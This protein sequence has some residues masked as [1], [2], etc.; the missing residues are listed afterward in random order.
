MTDSALITDLFNF[1]AD[2]ASF[3][4]RTKGSLDGFSSNHGALLV[5]SPHLLSKYAAHLARP[6]FYPNLELTS[7]NRQQMAARLNCITLPAIEA[8]NDLHI[9]RARRFVSDLL[10]VDLSLVQVMLTRTVGE[11]ADSTATVF[12]CGVREH[13][14]VAPQASRDPEGMLVRQFGIAGY[15]AATRAKGGLGSLVVDLVTQEMA[16]HFA[17]TRYARECQS[18]ELVLSKQRL[19][20]VWEFAKGIANAPTQPLAF[21]ASDLGAD[22]IR[23]YGA[24]FCQASITNLYDCLPDGKGIIAGAAGFLGYA[25]AIA[26]E[27]DLEGVMRLIRQYSG[28]KALEVSLAEAIT[29]YEPA[30]ILGFNDRLAEMIRS[31]PEPCTGRE[32]A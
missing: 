6:S 10:G 23:D 9:Q 4:A 30:Q 32:C 3:L 25:M 16:G 12:P 11:P 17:A 24:Q 20:I 19:L 2:R 18:P 29:A 15:Y 26:L 13:V 27:D 7:D 21:I 14:I 8:V 28:E 1:E 5:E 22:L 31:V